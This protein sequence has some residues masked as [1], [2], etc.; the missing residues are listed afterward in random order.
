M[1]SFEHVTAGSLETLYDYFKNGWNTRIIAGGT[2]LLHEMKNGIISPDR[3]LDIKNIPDLEFVREENGGLVIGALTRI[4]ELERN[5]LVRENAELLTKAAGEAAS[6]QLRNMGTIAGNIC[7]R[8]RC[9]Y[10]RNKDIP[11]L[12]KGGEKCFAVIGENR[13]HA[14]LGG[15]PCHIVCPSDLAP[16]LTAL[17]AELEIANK[18]G[19]RRISIDD[20]FV[21]PQTNAYRENVLEPT[22]II[23]KILIPSRGFNHNGKINRSVFLKARERQSWDFALASVAL[24]I[25]MEENTISSAGVAFGGVAPLPWRSE[26]VEELLIG[27]KVTNDTVEAIADAAAEAGI[28]GARAL[29]DN[30]YKIKLLQ[31]LLRNAVME[32]AV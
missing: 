17:R 12:R 21:G 31:G 20:F 7:Q 3:L 13:Y 24:N 4:A 18:E 5:V 9:W 14:V 26:K 19:K 25:T 11:C 2:D 29:R 22:D 30:G 1:N 32:L 28:A 10:Y 27:K 15:G 23:V 8:P 16:A 6:P